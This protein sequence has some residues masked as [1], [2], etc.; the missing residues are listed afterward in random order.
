MLKSHLSLLDSRPGLF[1]PPVTAFQF[2]QIESHAIATIQML[3]SFFMLSH[4]RHFTQVIFA[5][6]SSQNAL[7]YQSRRYHELSCYSFPGGPA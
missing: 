5:L 4:Y 6:F 7:N 3:Y 2:V 1:H